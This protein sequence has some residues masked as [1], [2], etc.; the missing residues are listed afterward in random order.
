MADRTIILRPT[1]Q[2]RALLEQLVAVGLYGTT[3]EE[4]VKYLI[5]SELAK[6]LRESDRFLSLP[7]PPKRRK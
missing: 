6:M 4:V 2:V 7:P 5:T 3:V 1:R